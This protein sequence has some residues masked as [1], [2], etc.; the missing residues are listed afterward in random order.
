MILRLVVVVVGVGCGKNVMMTLGLE[1]SF[2]VLGSGPFLVVR[3][4]G[5]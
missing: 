5:G 3:N 1:Q 2:L 4:G